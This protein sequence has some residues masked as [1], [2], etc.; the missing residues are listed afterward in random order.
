MMVVQA[1]A[2]VITT[3]IQIAQVRL[4]RVMLAH[5][6]LVVEMDGRLAVVVAQVLR[7]LLHFTELA[8]TM[9]IQVVVV[10]E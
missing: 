9:D 2:V 5:L 7:L 10:L 6:G 4:V 1:V 3:T 8:E